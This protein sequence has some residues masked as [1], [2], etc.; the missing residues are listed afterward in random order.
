[1]RRACRCPQYLRTVLQEI[2]GRFC[3][4]RVSREAPPQFVVTA[5]APNVLCRQWLE[6]RARRCIP[7][8]LSADTRVAHSMDTSL[9]KLQGL[10]MGMEA[11][12]AAAHGVAGSDS[13]ELAR[14]SVLVFTH[15]CSVITHSDAQRND[16]QESHPC[17]LSWLLD[18]TH[19]LSARPSWA[20]PGF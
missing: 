12:S 9:S 10:A 5:S 20:S 2:T 18:T 7:V 15:H 1:M 16:A 4:G 13:A 8:G 3:K 17:S 11:R 14:S 6:S 19:Q